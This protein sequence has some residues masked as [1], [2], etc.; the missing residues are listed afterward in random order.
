MDSKFLI[1]IEK[2]SELNGQKAEAFFNYLKNISKNKTQ[3]ILKGTK[4]NGDW[5]CDV[6]ECSIP[7][8]KFFG[9]RLPA[10]NDTNAEGA[11]LLVSLS[12]K[13]LPFVLENNTTFIFGEDKVT[14]KKGSLKM[15]ESYETS[16]SEIESLLSQY[17]AAHNSSVDGAIKFEL[18]KDSN[19]L[20]YL[21]NISN[22]EATFYVG[23]NALTYRE[24]SF[25][26]RTPVEENPI[27]ADEIFINAYLAMKIQNVLS[28]CDSMELYLTDSHTNIQGFLNGEKIVQNISARFEEVD[29]N[30]TDEDLAG[31]SPVDGP[32]LNK[33]ELSANSFFECFSEYSRSIQNFMDFKKSTFKLCKNGAGLSVG[34]N[35]DGSNKLATFNIGEVAQEEPDPSMFSN[36]FV[37]IPLSTLKNIVEDNQTISFEFDSGEDTAVLIKSG[38]KVCLSGKL[39]D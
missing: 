17:E 2:I 13:V 19:I 25:F 30:P 37:S 34:L 12:T 27:G 23:R 38:E 20:H 15:Q 4:E 31:I 33:I 14:I 28:Y 26:F 5:V 11:K 9:I 7:T 39:F 16:P 32:E 1:D 29:S 18:K 10:V 3:V 8:S 6:Y 21:Q 36:W 24:D 35:N 22:L